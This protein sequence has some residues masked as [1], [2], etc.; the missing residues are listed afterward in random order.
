VPDKKRR[1]PRSA[2][3]A[4]SRIRPDLAATA[5]A[6]VYPYRSNAAV[7]SRRELF[8]LK[9]RFRRVNR[10]WGVPDDVAG[11]VGTKPDPATDEGFRPEVNHTEFTQ[12]AFSN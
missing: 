2:A 4:G 9:N 8:T 12:W 7:A 11:T 5:V 10:R 1:K 6:L 3:T